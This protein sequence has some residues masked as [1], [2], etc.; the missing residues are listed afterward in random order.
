MMDGAHIGFHAA[1]IN[2]GEYKRE[3][4]LGNALIGAYLYQLGLSDRVIEFVTSPGPEDELN[5]L[6]LRAAQALGIE[7]SRSPY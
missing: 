2:Y 6:T 5:W 7:I 1:Y 3:T 4:G